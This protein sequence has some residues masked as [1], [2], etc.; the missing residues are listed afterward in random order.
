MLNTERG[1]I[2]QSETGV[3]AHHVTLVVLFN[4]QISSKDDVDVQRTKSPLEGNPSSHSVLP[5]VEEKQK[6]LSF[7]YYLDQLSQIWTRLNLILL[8]F[9]TE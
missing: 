5:D 8:T 6:N 3:T 9:A 2:K 4:R 7:F 1:L